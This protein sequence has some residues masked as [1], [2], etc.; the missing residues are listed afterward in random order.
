MTLGL[1]TPLKNVPSFLNVTVWVSINTKSELISPCSATCHICHLNVNITYMIHMYLSSLLMVIF[2]LMATI[3][4]RH[5]KFQLFCLQ[6]CLMNLQAV[7]RQFLLLVLQKHKRQ[8]HFIPPFCSKMQ[9][10][11]TLRFVPQFSRSG[12]C[13]SN[14][15]VHIPIPPRAVIWLLPSQQ[16]GSPRTFLTCCKP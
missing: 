10:R 12:G 1:P 2:I 6:T 16:K 11:V 13:C 3:L 14:M 8:K 4:T 7:W 5:H 9:W 15:T